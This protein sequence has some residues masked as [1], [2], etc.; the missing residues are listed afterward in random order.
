MLVAGGALGTVVPVAGA[1]PPTRADL[2]PPG[3][4]VLESFDETPVAPGMTLTEFARLEDDGWT[5]GSVLTV[6][7]DEDITADYQY[8]GTVT[9]PET[10]G[11]GA[12]RVG[13]R[14]A[15]NGDFFDINNSFAPHGIGVSQ[16]EGLVTSPAPGHEDA[17]VFGADGAAG[18]AEVFLEGTVS[19]DSTG[20]EFPLTAVNSHA[21][22]K[23]GVG[24]Y[25]SAWGDYPRETV[26]GEAADVVEVLVNDGV[27]TSI[28]DAAGTGDLPAGT[29]AL[30]GREAG[31]LD[32]RTLS[33]GDAVDISYAPTSEFGEVQTAL[34]GNHVLV[35]DGT[36]NPGG[37]TALHP[38]SAL[39]FDEDHDTMYLVLVEGRLADAAG[40]SLPSLAEFMVDLGA[41]DA[42]NIDG[43]GSSTLVV[44]EPARDD[45]AVVNRPTDGAPREVANGLSL[46]TGDGSG[47]LS[48]FRVDPVASQDLASLEESA[49]VDDAVRTFPGLSRT[50]QAW[51]HD[52]T[53]SPVDV[54][55][56][57]SSVDPRVAR[58][59]A[60]PGHETVITGG[61]HAGTTT[62]QAGRRGDRPLG[63][64]PLGEG[65]EREQGEHV[66]GVASVGRE[67]DT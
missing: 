7:L 42:L 34:G 39:G 28:A 55:P 10:I 4:A 48:G 1:E 62:I 38:R 44:Q 24:L 37:D 33:V 65:P 17:V 25:T 9:E 14:A 41:H 63:D 50:V 29:V 35:E 5:T 30:V 49:P 47:E 8:S 45:L 11:A 22:D 51:G 58:V 31:A 21:V 12:E 20:D 43:G 27:V 2:T 67:S 13:A 23:D 46:F 15:I 59:P 53:L 19:R 40:M 66:H 16:D 32:L 54:A 18:L 64:R 52:E 6:E 3:E 56:Q 61:P 36:P 26:I 60:R 57:W